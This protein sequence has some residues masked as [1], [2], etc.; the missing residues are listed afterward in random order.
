[1]KNQKRVYPSSQ[2]EL[3]TISKIGWQNCA[4]NLG[5]FS[6]LKPKYTQEYVAG[7]QAE[8]DAMHLLP[9]LRQ[10]TEVAESLHVLLKEDA[11]AC[12]NMWLRL[13]NHIREGFQ[14][15]LVASKLDAAGQSY[16]IKASGNWDSCE[17]MMKA[18]SAFI[19][20]NKA[21]LLLN[22]NMPESFPADF[23]NTFEKFRKLH[24]DYLKSGTNS[25]LATN[26]KLMAANKVYESLMSMFTDAREIFKTDEPMLKIFTFN[27]LWKSISKP[28][29]AKLKGT[30]VSSDEQ[31]VN[32]QGALITVVE[33]GAEALTDSHGA[34]LF[35]SIAGGVYDLSVKLNGYKPLLL[36]DTEIEAAIPNI[37]NIIMEAE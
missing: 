29:A 33:T 14:E 27:Y 23:E 2:A 35:P 25:V 28:G 9:D 12:I 1:M 32:L 37:L 17:M 19:T 5:L 11:K 8:A 36:E 6:N 7:K 34:F 22:Q 31:P 24:Y 10:R 26:A 21:G 13:K 20:E 15:S 3:Y 16:Y 4:V 30:V 18:G